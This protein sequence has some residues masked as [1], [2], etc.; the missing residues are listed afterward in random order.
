[1]VAAGLPR[2]RFHDFRHAAGSIALAE[3]ASLRA[4]QEMLGHKSIATTA[5]I[6]AHVYEAELDATTAAVDAAIRRYG[7][8]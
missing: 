5:N 3:G 7:D 1:M 2:Q 8:L 4:V 6:Y